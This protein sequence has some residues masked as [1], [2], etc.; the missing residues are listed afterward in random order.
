MRMKQM[1]V[2]GRMSALRRGLALVC[3]ALVGAA[4]FA[5]SADEPAATYCVIDLSAGADATSYPVSY[6]DA[7]PEGGWTDEYKT[8][9]IVLRR[10]KRGSFVMGT[11]QSDESCRVTLTKPFYMGVFEVTQR[12]WELVMDENPSEF[13]GT[14]AKPVECVSY[15]D[16]RGFEEGAQWPAS[17][18]VDEGSFLGAL[19]T[20]TGI[21]FDLPTE[22]QWEYACRAGTTTKY[23][24]GDTE[25]DLASAGWYDGNSSTNDYPRGRKYPVGEKRANAWGLYDM[26]GNVWEWCLNWQGDSVKPLGGAD[27]VGA[28]SPGSEGYRYYRGGAYGYATFNATSSSRNS[29]RPSY[30]NQEIGFRLFCTVRV[31]G[32]YGPFVPGEPVSIALPDLVGYAAKGLPAGLKFNAKTGAIT[33][34]ATKP[35]GETG[36]TVTI[37]KRG[38]ETYTTQIVVGPFPVLSVSAPDA[39]AT[40]K[41]TGAG[42]YSKDKKVSLRATAAKG[43]VP[44]GWYVDAACT[45]PLEDEGGLDFR[46]PTFPYVMPERD[47]TV[48]AAFVPSNQDA[49]SIGLRL[50]VR[51]NPAYWTTEEANDIR[52]YMPSSPITF[53]LDVASASLPRVVL[54]G[55][56]PGLKF[57]AKVLDVKATKTTPAAHYAANTIYGT[58]TKSGVYVVTA[59]ITNATVKKAVTRRFTIIVDNQT[60]ANERLRVTDAGG[61]VT[62]LQNGRGESTRSTRACRSTTSRRLR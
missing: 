16:I 42:V 1:S 5:A 52:F 43:F 10:I 34:A 55:L 54:T 27:P 19:R 50:V 49:S 30:R 21:D 41:V 45:A 62:A 17:S 44:A 60:D 12:Q 35:T 61:G 25:A 20:K 32:A 58:P 53:F 47:A 59:K 24:T 39:P 8:T 13:S 3:A 15:F 57:T 23:N 7:V 4:V 46:T 51:N 33:G 36:V 40:C 6:L 18:A 26:H 2:Y 37:T 38:A 22:A 28:T 14:A 9:K 56:P 11:R 29:F 48:Y 31:N